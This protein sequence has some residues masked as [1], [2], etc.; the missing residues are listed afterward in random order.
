MHKQLMQGGPAWAS[1]GSSTVNM[2]SYKVWPHKVKFIVSSNTWSAELA[3]CEKQKTNRA[4]LRANSV[5]VRVSHPLC[6]V[7]KCKA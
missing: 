1:L 4:W 3:K 2:Y 6:E 5:W 7:S